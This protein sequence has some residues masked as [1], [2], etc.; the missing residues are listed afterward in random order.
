MGVCWSC[1]APCIHTAAADAG[2]SAARIVAGLIPGV[3]SGMGPTLSQTSLLAWHFPVAGRGCLMRRPPYFDN[4]RSTNWSWT[5]SWC[6]H[7]ESPWLFSCSVEPTMS[8]NNTVAST[9]SLVGLHRGPQIGAK[10]VTPPQWS[11]RPVLQGLNVCDDHRDGRPDNQNP[12][13]NRDGR[14]DQRHR[15]QFHFHDFLL[16]TVRGCIPG[17]TT[18]RRLITSAATPAA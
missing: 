17:S 14:R 16:S 9:R 10:R 13:R 6:R 12:N 4:D 1:V 2:R 7:H 11:G 8:V 18:R 15:V 5:S 3:P